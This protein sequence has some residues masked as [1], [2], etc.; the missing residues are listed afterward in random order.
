MDSPRD[1]ARH[2]ADALAIS[3]A[4][5]T[6]AAPVSHL[7]LLE[8]IVETAAHVLRAEAAS[9]LLLEEETDELVFEVATGAK[10][11][12]TKKFRVPLG[13][14]VAGTVAATGQPLAIA[15]VDNEARAKDISEQIGY[16][17]SSLLCVPLYYGDRIIGVLE[18]LDKRGAETFGP[19]DIDALTLFASQ[20]AVAIEYS[21]TQGDLA[22][23]VAR[24]IES[25]GDGGEGNPYDH[26][27]VAAA[28]SDDPAYG[29]TL[30]LASLVHEI[31]RRGDAEFNTCRAFL[32]DFAEYLRSRG[33]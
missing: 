29:R 3:A 24:L 15:G 28:V 8:M 21:R 2:L 16:E 19:D 1:T 10:A 26:R 7:R 32:S 30:E 22:A 27:A 13:H 23:V 4:A 25:L 33:R 9:L 31:A 17:P 18:L 14:G 11:D 20:A 5:G 6:I 12:E